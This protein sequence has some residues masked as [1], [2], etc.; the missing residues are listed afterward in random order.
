MSPNIFI[1]SGPIRSGKTSAL[2]EFWERN[3]IRMDGFITPVIDDSR[4][5]IFL[6]TDEEFPFEIDDQNSTDSISV[7]RFRFSLETFRIAKDRIRRFSSS[8]A[9][10]IIIDELGK[11]EMENEGFEPELGKLIESFKSNPSSQI[12]ILVIRNTLLAKAIDKYKIE[13]APVLSLEL[14]KSKFLDT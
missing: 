6:D 11:L 5:L 12:L 14:F 1:L 13:D 3:V 7:G 10:L 9:P 2:M 8:T 4:K